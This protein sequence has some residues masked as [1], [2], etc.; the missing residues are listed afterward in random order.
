MIQSLSLKNIKKID[1]SKMLDLLLDF[2]SQLKVAQDLAKKAVILFEKRE[3]K[4][5]VFAGLGG[6]A[7]GAGLTSSP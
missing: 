6:S 2:P 5:I 4:K 7:I 1:K 3:F